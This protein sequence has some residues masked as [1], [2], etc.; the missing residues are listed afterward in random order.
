MTF[1]SCALEF[2]KIA[3][4]GRRAGRSRSCSLCLRGN[5][6]NPQWSSM[7]FVSMRADRRSRRTNNYS[8]LPSAEE[9]VP[10]KDWNWECG[11]G[12]CQKTHPYGSEWYSLFAY[13]GVQV[14]LAS[15]V[16]MR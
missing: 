5:K 15:G 3:G 10:P 2:V 16:S 13:V 11:A 4:W 7:V 14:P 12:D 6:A 8:G 1:S 9:T